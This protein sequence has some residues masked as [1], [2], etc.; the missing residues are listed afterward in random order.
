[1]AGSLLLK[2]KKRDHLS[3]EETEVVK[4]LC[5]AGKAFKPGEPIVREG[6]RP[7]FSSIVQS[8]WAG[9][10]K[11]LAEGR[12]TISAVHLAG[13]FVDL[14]SFLLKPMDHTVV[15]LTECRISTVPHDRLK[16]ATERH[17]H[18]ARLFWL[19]TLVD[20]AIHREWIAC[21]GR[22]TA[23]SRLA[24]LFCELL[25][26]TEAVDLS[27]GLSYG[28]PLKQ[29]VLADCL[30]ITAVHVNRSLKALRRDGLIKF[31][32]GRLTIANWD[33][34]TELADFDPT[35]LNLTSE[36]R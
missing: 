15:A 21:L 18:L 19:E 3:A 26:R 14:H 22:R 1:M 33:R 16:A 28:L 29:A 32:D 2:L 27:D 6:D 7:G 30:G 35:Y 20:A 5:A 9:R 23:A 8:G 13:D 25:M 11:F 12:R 34:L 24:H 17:P 36:P 4:A 31:D 10:V